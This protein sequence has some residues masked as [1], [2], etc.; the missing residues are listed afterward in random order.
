MPTSVPSR[1][2]FFGLTWAGMTS[3]MAPTGPA[4]ATVAPTPWGAT[5]SP[6]QLAWHK[7]ETYGF[8]HFTVNTFTDREWGLGDEDPAIF[9]PTD[10]SAEQIVAACKSTLR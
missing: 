4:F 1:R 6:R 7:L 10:Y 9:N 5:P 8:L 2:T 3:A